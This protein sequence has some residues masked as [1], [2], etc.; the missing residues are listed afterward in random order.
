MIKLFTETPRLLQEKHIVKF[1]DEFRK[2][3]TADFA[4]KYYRIS[5][6]QQV[7]F[8]RHWIIPSGVNPPAGG[9]ANDYKD[10]V[11]SNAASGKE[12][13]YPDVENE[14]Y[15]VLVGFGEGFLAYPQIPGSRYFYKL[16]YSDM[17]PDPTNTTK[18][19]IGPWK[20]SDSPYYNPC[21][22]LSFIYK[23]TPLKMRLYVDSADEYEKV[24]IRFLINRC[25]IERITPTPEEVSK[26]RL[27]R[28]YSELGKGI[29]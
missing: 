1:S 11:L 6:T 13:L 14:I 12:N 25:N 23:L 18:R 22:R 21:L 20:A 4:G 24:I 5:N 29:E 2:G 16:G 3:D 27:V 19:Y 26:A 10:I 15:E 28:Y 9:V 7:S 8:D 17:L